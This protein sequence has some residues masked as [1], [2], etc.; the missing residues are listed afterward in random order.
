MFNVRYFSHTA[1]VLLLGIMYM[2]P[3]RIIYA[4]PTIHAGLLQTIH[5]SAWTP[6]SPDT[7][8]ITYIPSTNQLLVSDS[9]VD[10][11][12][13]F[14]GVNLFYTNL[15]G[16]LEKTGSTTSLIGSKSYE[17]TGISYD[18]TTNHLFFSDDDAMRIYQLT[19]G[20]DG[21]F[22]SSDDGVSYF[23][24]SA[25][26]STDPE[27]VAVGQNDLWIASGAD[28]MVFH[29]TKN[30]TLLS[31]FDTAPAGL[32]DLEGVAYNSYS[33]TVYVLSLSPITIGEFTTNGTLIRYINISAASSEAP[34]DLV[35][36]P[37]S[38]TSDNPNETSLY[39]VDRGIDN[40]E[41]P[42]ENDGSIYEMSVPQLSPTGTVSPTQSQT[43]T[44]TPP[45]EGKPGDANG[46]TL[47][48][49]RD[50]VVWVNH[51]GTSSN[52]S[53]NGDFNNDRL[54]DGRDYMVWVNNY[55]K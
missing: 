55:G 41:V 1:L 28:H 6:P 25:F 3:L 48:D 23:N 27:S 34:A 29:T 31:S 53:T 43:A 35:F 11:M 22:G 40:N 54:I 24:T 9:E 13:I 15:Q 21:L 4:V 39:I 46:D 50:Y 49:G 36:A 12:P 17:P 52:G 5:T 38:N 37:T 47:V 30:G 42:S 45:A 2:H 32:N 8:G 33:Q 19:S 7:A 16:V 10:E 20:N 44:T 18:E 51:Y 26:G 14:T